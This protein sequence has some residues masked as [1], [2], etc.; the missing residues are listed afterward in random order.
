[1]N[2]DFTS[3]NKRQKNA[4]KHYTSL[5]PSVKISTFSLLKKMPITVRTVE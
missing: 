5:I 1:M 2:A 4:T 3:M